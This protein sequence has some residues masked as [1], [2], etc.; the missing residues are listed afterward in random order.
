MTIKLFAPDREAEP[1]ANGSRRCEIF[2]WI[3]Q[4]FES[5]ENCGRPFWDHLYEPPFGGTTPLFHVKQYDTSR[6]MWVWKPVACSITRERAEACRAKWE[7]YTA[8]ASEVG[9]DQ[10]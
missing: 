2:H 4:T 3:G 5:C 6:G 9:G 8:R 7:G 1:P 10:Q